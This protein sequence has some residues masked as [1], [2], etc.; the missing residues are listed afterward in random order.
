MNETNKPTQHELDT[1]KAASDQAIAAA[2]TAAKALNSCLQGRGYFGAIPSNE[3]EKAIWN[4]YNA[5]WQAA[6]QRAREATAAFM[7]AFDA[8]HASDHASENVDTGDWE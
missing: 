6:N 4:Q 7:A 3:E 2:D 5:A 8:F 1:L